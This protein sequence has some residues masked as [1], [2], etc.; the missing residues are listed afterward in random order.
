L[1]VVDATSWPGGPVPSWPPAVSG[2]RFT[3]PA[4]RG[5]PH[6]VSTDG[7]GHCSSCGRAVKLR[8]DGTVVTHKTIDEH[9]PGSG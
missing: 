9:C 1:V 6:L 4:G 8:L 2:Q 7:T 5:T 3:P